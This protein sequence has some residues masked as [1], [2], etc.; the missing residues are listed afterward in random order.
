MRKWEPIKK[1]CIKSY[2]VFDLMLE[3]YLSPRTGRPYP[4]FVL[5]TSDWVNIVPLTP[6]NHVV[7]IRQFRAGIRSFTL[8]V[9][10][11]L[12]NASDES[13]LEAATRELKEETGYEGGRIV[14]LGSV[15][16]N[17]AIMNNRCHF[18]LATDVR[19][20][21]GQN[22]DPGED[23]DIQLIPLEQIPTLIREEQI[24]HSLVLNAFCRFQNFQSP[25]SLDR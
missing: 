14:S 19:K 17:P 10:G 3:T 7:M 22:L 5:Q 12:V 18:F 9:P 25:Q 8:E 4:F 20:T 23:I 6:D 16:P 2:P 15:H 11:G 21:C 24:T 1:E 13:P